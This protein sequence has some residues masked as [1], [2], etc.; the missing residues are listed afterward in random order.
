MFFWGQY[1]CEVCF[2]I[3]SM[4]AQLFAGFG[5]PC[6]RGCLEKSLTRQRSIV[7][8]DFSTVFGYGEHDG[9]K[10]FEKN[11]SVIGNGPHL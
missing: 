2:D 5:P 11:V 7:T 9:K 8:S 10:F 4:G 3:D 1:H 6:M